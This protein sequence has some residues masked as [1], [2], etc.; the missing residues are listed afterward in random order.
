MSIDNYVGIITSTNP[1]VLQI[2]YYYSFK[3]L[4]WNV[5]GAVFGFDYANF[6]KHNSTEHL[7]ATI[8]N[9]IFKSIE[10]QNNII[11]ECQKC[12][13]PKKPSI[14]DIHIYFHDEFTYDVAVDM[15]I[16]KR[17]NI[18]A[19][20]WNAC[21]FFL[22]LYQEILAIDIDAWYVGTYEIDKKENRFFSCFQTINWATGPDC[23]WIEKNSTTFYKDLIK[24]GIHEIIEI[25]CDKVS[26]D[27]DQNLDIEESSI[28]SNAQ[29]S[30]TEK[31]SNRLESV[32]KLY[33]SEKAKHKHI[34][35]VEKAEHKRMLEAERRKY[36]RMLEAERE[37]YKRMLE[38]QRK[39]KKRI[40][41]FHMQST[42][43]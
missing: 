16:L 8:E 18:K 11:A 20:I 12:T 32:I 29:G 31:L 3:R 34:V 19:G 15:R 28:Q 25:S 33:E 35:E 30:V 1:D 2:Q 37:K 10:H 24:K 14:N 40:R 4:T 26:N 9:E 43:K 22:K 36:K 41:M 5:N 21:D 39:E 13:A 6:K 23:T 42:L 27:F 7:I 38:A 17:I